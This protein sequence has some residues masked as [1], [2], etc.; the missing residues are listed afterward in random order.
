M[1]T[2]IPHVRLPLAA[3]LAFLM[4]SLVSSMIFG[5]AAAGPAAQ[6]PSAIA[7]LPPSNL[8]PAPP[9]ASSLPDAP[10]FASP[11]PAAPAGP[12]DRG[13]RGGE[14]WEGQRRYGPL[15]RASIG[16]DISLLGIG[17][18]PSVILSQDFDA[19][20]LLNFFHF[21]TG[22]F[23]IE[24]YRADAVLHL[25]SVGAALDCYPRNSIWRL[26]GGLMAHNGNNIGLTSTIVP[27]TSFT[28]DGQTYYSARPNAATGA[29]P[30]NGSGVLGL[31]A[32]QPEFLV[33]G[34][35]GRFI[36]RSERHWS[37]PSEFGVIFMGAPTIS[38]T[39][40]GWVCKDAAETNC[41]DINAPGSPLAAQ[42]NTALQAQETRWRNSL[43]SFTVYPIFSYSV[44]Y[45]FDLP[46]R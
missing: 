35:F 4:S 10:G 38:L 7:A 39:T 42:F 5:Q 25:L 21:D 41:T 43:R 22:S 26:S 1:T 3:L 45:S 19:R 29:V 33:S 15:S 46:E 31:D 24:G 40:A 16:A 37:F 12:H 13:Q 14:P 28:V 44:V 9:V 17:I 34:G 2:N 30:V 23:E 32:R 8:D 20:L 27:G 11:A 36:P 18:K 6:P